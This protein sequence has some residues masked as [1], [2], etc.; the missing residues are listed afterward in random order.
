MYNHLHKM[1]SPTTSPDLSPRSAAARVLS[2]MP[3]ITVQAMAPPSS[4]RRRNNVTFKG[5]PS[6]G[7]PGAV[8]GSGPPKGLACSQEAGVARPQPATGGAMPPP[9]PQVHP[10][11][12]PVGPPSGSAGMVE[13]MPGGSVPSGTSAAT[14]R[15]SRS[16]TSSDGEPMDISD[17]VDIGPSGRVQSKPAPQMAPKMVG[18]VPP[19]QPLRPFPSMQGARSFHPAQPMQTLQPLHPVQPIAM[20]TVQQATPFMQH[21]MPVAPGYYQP[22]PH[23]EMFRYGGMPRAIHPQ[24]ACGYTSAVQPPPQQPLNP[25]PTILSL[26]APLSKPSVSPVKQIAKSGLSAS[27]CPGL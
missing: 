27:F 5:P 8:L 7:A 15:A 19:S 11:I 17:G 12:L 4:L 2:G 6:L 10:A 13:S 16:V 25:P 1:P 3:F 21:G 9:P 14:A 24:S 23:A 26:S 18:F 22:P 20:Q